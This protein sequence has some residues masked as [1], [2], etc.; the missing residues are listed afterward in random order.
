MRHTGVGIHCFAG[1]F[2]IGMKRVHNVLCQL[3]IHNFGGETCKAHNTEFIN[4]SRWEDWPR[5]DADF[6]YGNPRCTAFSCYSAG[7][8]KAHGAFAAPTQDIMDLIQYG[9]RMGYPIIAFESVQPAFSVG[10]PLLHHIRDTYLKDAH[11]RI[12]HLFVNTAAEGNAQKRRRYFFV[13]YRDDRNFNVM[14]PKLRPYRT[15]VGDVLRPGTPLWDAPWNERKLRWTDEYDIHSITNLTDNEKAIIPLLR[16]NELLNDLGRRDPEALRIVSAYYYKQIYASNSNIPFGLHCV[17]R[18]SLKRACP[19]I[20]STSGRF[21]HP[22][23]HRPL[24][25]GELALLMGWPEGFIPRGKDPI[26]QIGKGVVPATGEWLGH[27]IAYYLD[28]AWGADDFESSYNHRT[29]HFE[30]A[31][32]THALNKPLEK[33]FNLTYYLPPIKED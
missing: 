22:V 14:T 7:S 26:A 30:G 6:C 16:Q 15:L 29:G 18:L 10:K 17:R 4:C 31:D 3:E 28:D 27:Q 33:V 12:A 25:V 1:G 21:V 5:I 2:T 24:K 19:I 13:A 23:H 20:I 8:E 32:Y 11:Y 9:V